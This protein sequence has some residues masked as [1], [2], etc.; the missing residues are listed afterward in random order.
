MSL[1]VGYI[2]Y[3]L[4]QRLLHSSLPS[5][6]RSGLANVMTPDMLEEI[7]HKYQLA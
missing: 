5:S 4:Q 3:V 2:G 6:H 1:E 7:W